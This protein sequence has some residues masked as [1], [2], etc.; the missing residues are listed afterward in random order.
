MYLNLFSVQVIFH[1]HIVWPGDFCL[2][3]QIFAHLIR[4]PACGRGVGLNGL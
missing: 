4:V 2:D 3:L 1:I